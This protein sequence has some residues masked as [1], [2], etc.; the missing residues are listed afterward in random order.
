MHLLVE[1]LIGS[2][3]A[4][5]TIDLGLFLFP[6]RQAM[7]A[8]YVIW[9]LDTWASQKVTC[10]PIGWLDHRSAL[11]H[12]PWEAVQIISGVAAAFSPDLLRKRGCRTLNGHSLDMRRRR[13]RRFEAVVSA[14]FP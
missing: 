13:D 1:L 2:V 4:Y 6:A 14:L 9:E 5:N 3:K 10:S 12:Q 8:H 11:S 7:T